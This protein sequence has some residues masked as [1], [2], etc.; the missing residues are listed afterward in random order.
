M[1]HWRDFQVLVDE[2]NAALQVKGLVPFRL[3]EAAFGRLNN[4]LMVAEYGSLEAY[5]RE[6]FAL[7]T[8]AACMDLWR[9]IGQHTDGTPWTDLWWRP[10]E[11]A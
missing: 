11:A 2:L 1:G 7:H 5:E 9:E 6:H 8:D 3:W 10:S 4:A